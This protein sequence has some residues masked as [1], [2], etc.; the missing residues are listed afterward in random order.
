MEFPYQ[1]LA[2]SPAPLPVTPKVFGFM[3]SQILVFIQ[4]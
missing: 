2:L 3:G 1:G 4:H